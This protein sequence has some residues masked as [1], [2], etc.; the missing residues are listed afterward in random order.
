MVINECPLVSAGLPLLMSAQRRVKHRSISNGS[1]TRSA[2]PR[3]VVA[4][5]GVGVYMLQPAIRSCR[6]LSPARPVHVVQRDAEKHDADYKIVSREGV[7]LARLKASSLAEVVVAEAASEA[8]LDAEIVAAD[9][10]RVVARHE[11]W[12]GGA[13]GWSLVV[14]APPKQIG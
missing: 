12:T 3:A 7:V 4:M 10:A 14:A 9:K 11:L 6:A 1:G 5:L 2:R 8:P 13:L